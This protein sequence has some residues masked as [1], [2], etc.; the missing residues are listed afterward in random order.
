MYRIAVFLF[1]IQ[2]NSTINCMGQ[3]HIKTAEQVVQANLD[4][5]NKRDLEGFMSY[6]SADIKLYNFADN[7]LVIEGME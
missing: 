1:L 2:L 3:S 6:F 5:Y 4:C 7:K